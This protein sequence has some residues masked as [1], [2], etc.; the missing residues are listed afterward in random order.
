MTFVE[1]PCIHV[2]M[3]DLGREEGL[4]MKTVQRLIQSLEKVSTWPAAKS[5]N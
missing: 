1:A 2:R 5:P 4:M 3:S